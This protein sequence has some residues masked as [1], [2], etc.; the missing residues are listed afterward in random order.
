[1]SH[2]TITESLNIVPRI[3]TMQTCVLHLLAPSFLHVIKKME[4]M[5]RNGVSAVLPP[6]AHQQ[7]PSP[8][9][10]LRKGIWNILSKWNALQMA[11]ENKW[12]GSDSLDKSHQLASDIESWFSKSKE[13]Q[14]V[15]DLESLLHESLLLTF[16]TEIEDGSIEEVAEQLMSL[17]E[18]V[19]GNHQCYIN[20]LIFGSR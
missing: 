12:G 14:S 17:H 3:I 6:T 15:E 11:V 20:K 8:V 13:P 5:G 2:P 16:N 19:Q 7:N 10:A 4:A 18:D 9:F 1:M